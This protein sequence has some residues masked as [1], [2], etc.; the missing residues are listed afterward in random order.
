MPTPFPGM[1]PFLESDWW[2]EFQATVAN[3]IHS[4]MVH[5]PQTRPGLWRCTSMPSP[6]PGMDRCLSGR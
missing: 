4:L 5:S 6:F 1:T 3:V 2:Q